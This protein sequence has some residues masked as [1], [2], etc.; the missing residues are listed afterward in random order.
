MFAL[1]KT[2]QTAL[3]SLYKMTVQKGWSNIRLGEIGYKPNWFQLGYDK[4]PGREAM[5]SSAVYACV[6]IISKELSRLNIHHYKMNADQSRELVTQSAASVVMRKPNQHQT[7]SDFMLYL[8]QSLLLEGNAYALVERNGSGAISALYPIPPDMIN[9]HR[10]EDQYSVLTRGDVYYQIGAEEVYVPQRDMLHIRVFTGADGLIGITPLQA[11]GPSIALGASIQNQSAAFFDNMSRPS[12]ILR[13]PNPISPEASKRYQ[14]QWHDAMSGK[15]SGRVAVLGNDFDW[16]PLTM[17]AVDS[18]VIEQ[19]KM[20]V[21]TIARVY[22]VPLYKLGDMTKATFSNVEGLQKA[23]ISETLGFYMKHLENAF[24]DLFG[25][26]ER[27][28][29]RMEFD[30]ERGLMRPDFEQRMSAY[31]KGIQGGIYAPNEARRRENLPPVEGGDEVYMQRQM[32][33]LDMLGE[34]AETQTAETTPL[35]DETEDPEATDEEVRSILR[36]HWKAA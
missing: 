36:K 25:F 8:M 14:E 23:F 32:W 20:S 6:W 15:H 26:N 29:N 19:Y 9:L 24:D 10:V 27:P 13:S 35:Q 12:G 3:R 17:S 2:V 5:R 33:P 18:E 22:S 21:E 11:L 34:D 7:F 31:A 30:L 4:T 28:N 1:R 16:R